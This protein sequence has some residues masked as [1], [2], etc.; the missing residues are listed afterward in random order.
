MLTGSRRSDDNGAILVLTALLLLVLM[1]FAALAVDAAS[2]W[3]EKR[4]VQSAAD[5][6][7]LAAVEAI[8]GTFRVNVDPNV[9]DVVAQ[10]ASDLVAVNAPGAIATVSPATGPT[11]TPPDQCRQPPERCL[12]NVVVDVA[13]SSDN[14]FA[15]AIGAADELAV[16]ADT[17]EAQIY[18][19][20]YPSLKLLPI[21]VD[22][23]DGS[24]LRCSP[25]DCAV[26]VF[27]P[28]IPLPTT[29]TT[30]TPTTLPPPPEPPEPPETEP[31]GSTGISLRGLRRVNDPAC[32]NAVE[33]IVANLVDGA[34]HLV[35]IDAATAEPR[36]EA[37]AC[38]DGHE[39]TMPNSAEAVPPLAVVAHDDFQ[40]LVPDEYR[41]QVHLW[42]YLAGVGACSPASYA[43]NLL[44]PPD[45][46]PDWD[47][48]LEE[49]V[50]FS[51]ATDLM[52]ECL[53]GNPIFDQRRIEADPRLGWALEMD[54]DGFVGFIPLWIHS[55]LDAAV[56]GELPVVSMLGDDG[57]SVF[58][59]DQDWLSDDA[60]EVD[61]SG[62]LSFKLID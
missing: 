14:A 19:I 47:P 18:L 30:T 42:D 56:P 51:L 38:A 60:T 4:R 5:L 25:V 48:L 46:I 54:G 35:E 34:D 58:L 22:E 49:A 13:G 24:P 36:H 53:G 62:R 43:P 6:A 29:T 57:Y 26:Y 31:I 16:G 3:S 41:G 33:T 17:A 9:D 23:L 10:V 28:P 39:L 61:P 12:T 8:S 11:V 40:S 2:G 55:V 7:A 32:S 50:L 37:L 52:E 1:G 45:L 59:L 27:D 44:L 21:G 15:P 20:E